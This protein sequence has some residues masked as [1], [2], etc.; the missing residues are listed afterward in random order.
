VLHGEKGH[1]NDEVEEGREAYYD[2]LEA[3]GHVN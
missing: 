3:L 2:A 1:H